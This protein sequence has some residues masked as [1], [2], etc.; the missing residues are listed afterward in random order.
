MVA[1]LV[2]V[3]GTAGV[4]IA[5]KRT[6]GGVAR[7]PAVAEVLSPSSSNID[8]YLLVG[9]DSRAA[10]DPN[11]GD[12]GGVSGN[13]SDTIMVLRYDRDTGDASLLSIPR[14]LYVDVPGHGKQRINGAYNDGPDRLVETVQQAL[15]IPVHH[16]VEID[17]AGFKT[18]VDSLGGVE[19][20]FLYPTRDDNTG[21]NITVPGCQVLDGTQALAYARSRHYEEL[22]DGEWKQD[23][24]SDLGRSTRQ[25]DFVNRTLQT[26]LAQ[27]KTNPF[28]AGEL[29]ESM[30]TALRID[31]NMDPVGAASSLRSAVDAGLLTY[32][33]PVVGQTIDGNAVLLLG[34]GAEAV[35]AYFRGD[36]P[37]PPAN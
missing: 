14:D 22:R 2:M 1:L 6:V 8:N 33:L 5:A 9:S 30:G 4:L 34:D 27:I 20:C 11:T 32:S 35:L 23:P 10:G 25:R 15:G 3:A 24:T 7:V 18:L 19:I 13:R 16:Y 31:E 28:R 29:I 17:F 21:L 12:T 26:A 37:P 36:G